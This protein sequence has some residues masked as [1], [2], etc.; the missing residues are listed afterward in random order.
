M[1]YYLN[2]STS[3][4]AAHDAGMDVPAVDLQLAVLN[5]DGS[6]RIQQKS[7]YIRPEQETLEGIR[8]GMRRR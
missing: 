1:E 2:C 6:I 3:L 8:N 5:D 7:T 4:S